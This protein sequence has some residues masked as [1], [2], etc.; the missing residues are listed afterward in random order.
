MIQGNLL[1]IISNRDQ[2]VLPVFVVVDPLYFLQDSPCPGF[3]P[4]GITA[5]DGQ[6]HNPLGGPHRGG[7]ERNQQQRTQTAEKRPD[8]HD[9][10]F[11]SS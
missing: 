10:T 5:G 4:S 1:I 2:T 3:S 7:E 11:S 9:F 6:L 8:I